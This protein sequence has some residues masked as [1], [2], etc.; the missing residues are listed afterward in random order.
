MSSDFL[1][2]CLASGAEVENLS[3]KNQIHSM[4]HVQCSNIQSELAVKKMKCV[5]KQTKNRQTGLQPNKMWNLVEPQGLHS[6]RRHN[7]M[8]CKW[9]F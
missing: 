9:V 2:L 7:R 8:S 6:T 4:Q 1:F 3:K 5:P